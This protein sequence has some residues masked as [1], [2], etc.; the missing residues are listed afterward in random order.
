[1]KRRTSTLALVATALVATAPA[2]CTSSRD[3]AEGS[4]AGRPGA[5]GTPGPGGVSPV[6][7]GSGGS[8]GPGTPGAAGSDGGITPAPYV[9]FDVNHVLSTGQSNS[10]AND[11]KPVLSTSQPYDNLMFD[12][13]V[14]TASG[15]DRNGCTTYEKPSSFVPLVEGDRFFDAVETMSSGLANEATKLAREKYGKGTHDV[16]VSLHG[17]S[18]NNYLC[19]RKGGCDWWEGTAYVKPFEEAMMQVADAKA[20]ASAAGK[21]H[22]VRA[23]T[24]IHGEHDHYAESGGYD[25]FPMRTSDGSGTL[26]DYGHALE[27]WQRDYE[28]GVQ[29]ITGQTVPI[30][31]LLNQYSHWNDVPHT[32]IAFQQLDAHVRSKGKVV[33]VGPTYM[34]PYS[35]DCLHF[36]NHGERWLGEYFA[37]AYTRIVV[38]GLPWEPLRPTAARIE[39]NAVT[40]DFHVPVPPLVLDT[41]RVVDPGSYGFEYVDD[42]ASSI[43][44]TRVELTGPAQVKVTLATAPTAAGKRIRYAYTFNGCAGPTSLARGNLRDSDRTPSQHGYDL[45]NWS[46]HF[47]L[48]I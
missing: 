43:A 45:F 11:A 29:A 5:P 13:G 15:C 17:R 44:I 19:L 25:Y 35:N 31:L 7:G 48:P 10:V 34:L 30:P 39:G 1:M 37:K 23:V 24:A 16:L 33:V 42:G 9:H 27:E 36:L 14:M 47:D 40:I 18:G 21:T 46:V 2:A 32:K 22:A 8:G 38:E 3:P 6:G 28:A 12:V 20:I 26:A 4:G 41:E